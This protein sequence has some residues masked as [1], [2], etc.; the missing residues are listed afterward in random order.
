[1]AEWSDYFDGR[2]GQCYLTT[3]NWLVRMLPHINRW[4]AHHVELLDVVQIRPKLHVNG[5]ALMAFLTNPSWRVL[6]TDTEVT[7]NL[8]K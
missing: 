7:S 6:T 4:L 1:M 3:R 5:P 2:T 8:M